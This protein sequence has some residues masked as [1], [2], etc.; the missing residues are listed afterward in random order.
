MHVYVQLDT[1][2]SNVST[3]VPTLRSLKQWH[4]SLHLPNAGPPPSH[5][6]GTNKNLP[7]AR[8][9]TPTDPLGPLSSHPT[10]RR[11]GP[12]DGAFPSCRLD[13]NRTHRFRPVTRPGS[14]SRFLNPTTTSH[15][16][17]LGHATEQ[18]RRAPTLPLPFLSSI[19]HGAHPFPSPPPPSPIPTPRLVLPYSKAPN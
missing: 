14:S 19:E 6:H 10:L 4:F 13:G 2:M 15:M 12:A 8:P 1:V 18:A 17:K 3:S 9:I 7:S 11:A 5:S 16:G